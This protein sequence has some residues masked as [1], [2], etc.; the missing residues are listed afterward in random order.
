MMPVMARVRDKRWCLASR[1]MRIAGCD[2]KWACPS[3]A[4]LAMSFVSLNPQGSETR[5][6]IGPRTASSHLPT[7]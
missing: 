6:G 4:V 3:Y 2:G 7:S 1:T 5:Y